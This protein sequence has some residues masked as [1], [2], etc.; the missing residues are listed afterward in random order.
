MN[1]KEINEIIA[2]FHRVHKSCVIVYAKD[3]DAYDRRECEYQS[4]GCSILWD[5]FGVE[6]ILICYWNPKVHPSK[7]GIITESKKEIP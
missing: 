4:K 1:Q 5:E 7:F 2:M 6:P 3:F